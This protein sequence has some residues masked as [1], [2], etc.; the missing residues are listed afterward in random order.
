MGLRR[1]GFSGESER[2][3]A[4]LAEE[5]VLEGG[6]GAWLERWLEVGL[7]KDWKLPQERLEIQSIN[8]YNFRME[9]PERQPSA[10][11]PQLSRDEYGLWSHFI[12]WGSEF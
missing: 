7:E 3:P 10:Q 11:A 9:G 5:E 4:R 2:S 6:Q 1:H 12:A 8:S